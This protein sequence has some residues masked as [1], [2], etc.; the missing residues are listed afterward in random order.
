M[1]RGNHHRLR[2]TKRMA[3]DRRPLQSRLSDVASDLLSHG[4]DDRS[5]GISARVTAGKAG[6]VN[7]VEAIAWHC[8]NRAFPS[9]W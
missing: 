6:H 5:A 7:K 4:L 8:R 3:Y 1:T 9:S 2:P